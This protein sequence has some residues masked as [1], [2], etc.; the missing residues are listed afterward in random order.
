[1]PP[2]EPPPSRRLGA[3]APSL[4]ARVPMYLALTAL[5]ASVATLL[6]MFRVPRPQGS[7]A[8]SASA[9]LSARPWPALSAS[10]A[11]PS[12]PGSSGMAATPSPASRVALGEVRVVKCS[13]RGTPKV[14]PERCDHLTSIE[15]AL[16]KAI[17]DSTSCAPS[18]PTG[19][20][21]SFV[22][23]VDTKAKKLHLW[24]GK[25]GTVKK[26]ESKGLVACVTK[27][28]P[29]PDWSTLAHQFE[30]YSIAILATYPPPLGTAAAVGAPLGGY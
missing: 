9:E 19:G 1:M 16:T 23:S 27:A 10:G 25:S 8:G 21:V 22:L 28:L 30:R 7:P 2:S 18:L 14:A 12:P 5:V 24:G 13:A 3:G 26:A 15:D 20:S 6:Y 29:T 17:R 4:A 11:V